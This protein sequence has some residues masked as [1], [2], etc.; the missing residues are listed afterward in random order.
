MTHIFVGEAH[1]FIDKMV[2]LVVELLGVLIDRT[3]PLARIE[4]L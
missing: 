4:E 2:P 3:I 1:I